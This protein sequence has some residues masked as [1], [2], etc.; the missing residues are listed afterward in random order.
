M[1][2]RAEI[3]RIIDAL[4]TKADDAHRYA[5]ELYLKGEYELSA[6]YDRHAHGFEYG[7]ALLKQL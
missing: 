3:E 5:E 1:I 4:Q 6:T 2:E 7:V